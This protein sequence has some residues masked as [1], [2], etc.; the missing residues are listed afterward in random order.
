MVSPLVV[1][2][3]QD[4]NRRISELEARLQKLEHLMDEK[5]ADD[6]WKDAIL[7]SRIRPGMSEADVRKLLGKPARVEKAIFTTWYYQIGRAHV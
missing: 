4:L 7:W 3:E 5:F 1:G 2:D 6:R